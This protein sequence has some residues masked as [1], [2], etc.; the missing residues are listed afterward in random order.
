M[1]DLK[2]KFTVLGP[3]GGPT[4]PKQEVVVGTF[5]TLVEAQL[6]QSTIA[7]GMSKIQSAL[8]TAYAAS[9][10]N[11]LGAIGWSIDKKDI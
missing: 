9:N 11:P 4:F 2:I 6:N 8:A 7:N 3:P 5:G 1:Y 10:Y